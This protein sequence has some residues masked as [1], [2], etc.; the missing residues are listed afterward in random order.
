M[1]TGKYDNF[2]Q[3]D[4]SIN[5]GNS[6]G[7]LFNLAG[8]V[9]GVNTAI[10]SPTGGSVGIGFAVPSSTFRPVVSEL[11][12]T[13]RRSAAISACESWTFPKKS[14]SAWR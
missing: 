14:R 8:E 12:H 1:N 13:V 10:L 7:P 4:A 11:L 6:G 2:I 3:T 5:K 9:V